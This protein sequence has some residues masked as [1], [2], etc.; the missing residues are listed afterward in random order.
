MP[1][2]TEAEFQAE[3]DLRT[4]INSKKIMKDSKRKKAAMAMA[5]KQKAEL[6]SVAKGK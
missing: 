5:K 2:K 3:D 1:H 6:E 4:I